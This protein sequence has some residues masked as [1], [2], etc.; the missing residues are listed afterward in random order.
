MA[1]VF[2]QNSVP[3]DSLLP[4]TGIDTFGDI[5]NV[6][7]RNSFVAAGVISFILLIF[8]AFQIIVAA[9]D[10]KKMEKAQSIITSSVVGLLVVVGSFWIIQ[11]IQRITGISILNPGV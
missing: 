4:T 9:G 11:I 1:R 5:V 8:G 3:L 10:A 2:A 6:V 7:V